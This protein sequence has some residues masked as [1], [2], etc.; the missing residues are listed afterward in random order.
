[1]ILAMLRLVLAPAPQIPVFRHDIETAMPS[2]LASLNSSL[3]KERSE[4][5]SLQVSTSGA[6][7]AQFSALTGKECILAI[8]GNRPDGALDTVA[9]DLDATV[10][11]EE[12][13]PPQYLMM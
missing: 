7:V 2:Y 8:E 12:L 5:V 4:A 11:Q 1:M 9:V 6:M 13:Q 10:A 3:I